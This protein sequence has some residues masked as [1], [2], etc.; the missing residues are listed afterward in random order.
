MKTARQSNSQAAGWS[1]GAHTAIAS[2]AAIGSVIAASSC[3]LPVLPF[4]L[5]AGFAGSS[6]MLA[7]LRPYLLGA[8]ILF[9]A[10]GF[11]QTWGSKRCG[12]KP[13]ILISVLLWTSAVFVIVSVFFPQVLANAAASL[14]AR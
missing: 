1:G 8:S 2:V 9:V 14:L 5:A 11:Y 13:G 12:R 7:A 6:A 4:V 10:Y 3:C